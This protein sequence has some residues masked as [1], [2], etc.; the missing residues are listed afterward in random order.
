MVSKSDFRSVV[1][2]QVWFVSALPY[3]F[4]FEGAPPKRANVSPYAQALRLVL[5]STVLC[6]ITCAIVHRVIVWRV[7]GGGGGEIS[8]IVQ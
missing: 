8:Q 1:R 4:L 2:G 5:R 7:K 6:T 3:C